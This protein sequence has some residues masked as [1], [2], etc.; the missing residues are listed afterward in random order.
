MDNDLKFIWSIVICMYLGCI[1]VTIVV[2]IE[3]RYELL[4]LWFGPIMF[5]FIVGLL[6]MGSN[7]YDRIQKENEEYYERMQK[8]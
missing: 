6:T 2:I 8:L 1:A 7:Q 5:T 4:A 3:N